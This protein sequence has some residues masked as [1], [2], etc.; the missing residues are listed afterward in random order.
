MNVLK[1]RR[2]D[3]VKMLL[4]L[5]AITVPLLS[6]GYSALQTTLNIRATVQNEALISVTYDCGNDNVYYEIVED[7]SEY[8][9][10]E[11]ICGNNIVAG[12]GTGV[13]A[14]PNVYKQTGWSLTS[15]GAKIVAA[16]FVE[17]T[18]LYP[19]YEKL[20][21]YAGTYQVIDDDNG[22][23]RVKFLSSANLN[24]LTE[25][26]VDL[27]LVGGGGG[28]A[29][30]NGAGGGGGYTTTSTYNTLT[31][32]T[33]YALNIG[34][35]GTTA[36]HGSRS[37]FMNGSSLIAFVDG[38]RAADGQT[39]GDGG[40]GG[41]VDTTGGSN[42]NWGTGISISYGFGGSQEYTTCEFGYGDTDDP[43]CETGYTLYSTGGDGAASGAS[44]SANTGD[45][46]DG[47]STGGAGGSGII[48]LQNYKD[49]TK[50]SHAFIYS[51]DVQSLTIN[52]ESM[53][54]FRVWGAQ[55]GSYYPAFGGT[56]GY[57]EGLKRIDAA[58]TL[59]TVI[60]G[61]GNA[62]TSKTATRVNGGYNGGGNAYGAT[63]KYVTGG[64]GATHIATATGVLSSLSSNQSAV[65]IVAGGGGGSAYESSTAIGTGG[66]GGGL[67]GATGDNGGKTY[68]VGTGGT[69]T[70]GGTGITSN[71]GFGQGG[72]AS[73]NGT[74]GGGG[75]YGGGAGQ[76]FSGGGGGSGY[77]GGLTVGTTEV[78]TKWGSGFATIVCTNGDRYLLIYDNNGG[79]GCSGMVEV[80]PG[81]DSSNLCVPTRNGYD[82]GGWYD[83]Q[84]GGT[85]ITS[86]SSI[87][88]DMVIYAHWIAPN[89][90]EYNGETFVRYHSTLAD[91]FAEATEGNTIKA[92]VNMNETVQPVLDANKELTLDINGKT[93]TTTSTLVNRWELTIVGSGTLTTSSD[94]N[95]IS[96]RGTLN[97]ANSGNLTNTNTSTSRVV[98]NNYATINKTGTGTIT[99]YNNAISGS[100][101]ITMTAGKINVSA[102][103]IQYGGSLVVEGDGNAEIT[104][105]T[106]ENL[107]NKYASTIYWNSTGTLTI[108]GDAY[109]KATGYDSSNQSATIQNATDYP[110][111]IIVNGGTIEGGTNTWVVISNGDLAGNEVIV[112]GG[113]IK[114]T[115]A[116]A[117]YNRGYGS[118]TILGGTI[119]A[120]SSSPAVQVADNGVLTIG[121]N[122]YAVNTTSPSITGSTY[123]VTVESAATFNFY[124]GV[125]KGA[126]GKS[127]AGSVTAMPTSYKVQKTTASSV[128]TAILV[129]TASSYYTLTYNNNGGEGCVGTKSAAQGSAIGDLCTPTNGFLT[130]LGWYT[131]TTWTTQVTA[132]TILTGNITVYARWSNEIVTIA[133]NCNGG[134][135]FAPSTVTY[136]PDSSVNLTEISCGIKTVANG[137]SNDL[138]QQNGWATTPGGTPLS[139]YIATDSTILYATFEKVLSYSGDATVSGEAGG[140]WAVYFTDSGSF[141]LTSSTTLDIHL[142]GGGQHGYAGTN[143]GFSQEPYVRYYTGGNGGQ[144]GFHNVLIG[145]TLSAGTYTVTVGAGGTGS[146]GAVG[147][148]S[149]IKNS[150]NVVLYDAP[151]GGSNATGY[152][153]GA[154]GGIGSVSAGMYSFESSTAGADSTIYDFNDSSTGIHRGGGGGGGGGARYNSQTDNWQYSNPS[155][156]G[157][158]GGGGPD[159]PAVANY[160]G[161]GLGCNKSKTSIGQDGSSGI[162]MIR[163]RV[164]SPI[165]SFVYTGEI[166][167]MIVQENSKCK[168]EVWGAQ[169]G[170]G[171]NYPG[172][173][174][175]YAYGEKIFTAGTELYIGVGGAGV[176]ANDSDVLVTGGY[177]GGGSAQYQ[178]GTGGGATHIATATGTLSSLSSNQSSVL[179]VAGGGGGHGF[180]DASTTGG[181]GGGSSGGAGGSISGY[182][183][184]GGAGTQTTGGA[185]G[186][187]GSGGTAGS[188]G[189]GGSGGAGVNS[190]HQHGAGAGGGGW[191]GGGGGT[192]R[193]GGG[194]G[195]SGY[196]GSLSNSSMTNGVQSGNG[197]ARITCYP[198]YNVKYNS[199]GGTG[200]S[201]SIAVNY[202]S[203]IGSLCTPTR[204][205]YTFMGWYTE[206]TGGNQITSSSTPNND[207]ILYAHWRSN[208]VN[209]TY[210]C[211]GGTEGNFT[212]TIN[213]GE[214]AVIPPGGCGSK[215][216]TGTG[217]GVS[218]NPGLYYQT[219]WATT[220][221]GS[222]ESTITANDDM[223]LYA[224]WAKAFTYSASYEVTSSG[225]TYRFVMKDSGS[226]VVNSNTYA[227]IF[228]VGG[229]GG[230]GTGNGG[231]GGGGGYTNT[232]SDQT[233]SA[234]NTYSI[235]VGSGGAAQ[236][237]GSQ[238]RFGSLA[239]ANG[240]SGGS[241]GGGGAGGSG[242]GT[243]GASNEVTHQPGNC[244]PNPVGGGNGGTNGAAGKKN[245]KGTSNYGTGQGSTTCEFGQGTY[246]GSCNSGVTM[247]AAGGNGGNGKEVW[248]DFNDN[249]SRSSSASAGSAGTANT[250]NGGNGG[251]AGGTGGAGGSG[252]VIIKGLI[253]ISRYTLTYNNNEGSGC[254]TKEIADGIPYGTLC[255]PTR[256]GY[257]F[258][259]W[260]TSASGGTQVTSNTIATGNTTIVAHW[261]DI[262][263]IPPTCTVTVTSNDG[264]DGIN[265]SVTCTPGGTA[266]NSSINPTGDTLLT[267]TKTYTVYDV[268]GNSATCSVTVTQQ[269]QKQTLEC[270][271]TYGRNCDACGYESCSG[272]CNASCASCWYCKGSQDQYWSTWSDVSSCTESSTRHC[273]TVYRGTPN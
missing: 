33:T 220:S 135:G 212:M 1:P 93:I 38:G 21:T 11:N 61:Q 44:G 101:S 16:N 128:E 141:T 219:G 148:T 124:D 172:G 77:V 79:T 203:S 217:T 120:T 184:G 221:T 213:G 238:S 12:T 54:S 91:A 142:L 98:I 27:F 32:N 92:L 208:N 237:A 158:Q 74:A 179:I 87:T 13:S 143:Y 99:G 233:L 46:G 182:P 256:S 64:G 190:S 251:K 103:G 207:L 169:G 71:S 173:L 3:L 131:D 104:G 161:G 270:R 40:S 155:S 247:Y 55:A 231:G 177:N 67:T 205:D 6:I 166:Q 225:D 50:D 25:E 147:G 107:S 224:V 236:T 18:T 193:D 196:V 80:Q 198:K 41:S 146:S 255:T 167:G 75:W 253:S 35:G 144:G 76:Y 122:D 52:R 49:R 19:Y 252:I 109:I 195:G 22:D 265:T 28:G 85:Q 227:D 168:L 9:L 43:D 81:F 60:G 5:F 89:Y 157:S 30:S 211:N 118:T 115:G 192:G 111:T 100:G 250:G 113:L 116:Q 62:S 261:I 273:R 82:F 164:E 106:I 114:S 53:C 245:A 58:T 15:G 156:G 228:L 136:P 149:S 185:R 266:C 214:N 145:E 45:G 138:Y 226:M 126:S 133:Y 176:K 123:G 243:G 181:T 194:G 24:W 36:S 218:S 78:G 90:G 132:S 175:G 239:T 263:T 7:I 216:I 186:S 137:G 121:N 183:G 84:I 254:T 246:G 174:G 26:I 257:V 258:D 249:C 96:N 105:G 127:I 130:F 259:G 272:N 119:T 112:N 248:E 242:G 14:T 68:T 189:Q 51:G 222:A 187:S 108:G 165:K 10:Y 117:I 260:W 160:G 268:S 129:P 199:N 204:T 39:A 88:T 102:T 86:N 73:S 152:L 65:L 59:Y 201:G 267:S 229:G 20:F 23:Y 269:R 235:T 170:T 151:G 47:G 200:C 154:A 240:G 63:D 17:N 48:E 8:E 95:L 34:N 215:L 234:G 150:Q 110:G 162:V 70:A 29:S 178:A 153:G 171:D 262:T 140:N 72:S 69:Q 191:Y 232:V 4:I 209:V 2:N 42:G 180:Y 210:N 188:F 31:A 202:G 97:L 244:N 163:K 125:I 57:S 206:N 241:G 230:G 66:A 94:I 159:V 197:Y 134:N 139:T 264:L 56:G 83:S 37:T 271:E 223:T